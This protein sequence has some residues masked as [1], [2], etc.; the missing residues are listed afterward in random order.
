MARL[1]IAAALASASFVLLLVFQLLSS[2]GFP[3]FDFLHLRPEPPLGYPTSHQIPINPP[4]ANFGSLKDGT[5]YLLG[6]GK[7]DIT[8]YGFESH[9]K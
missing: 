1:P 2:F 8:G 3:K 4:S 7:A 5:R 6:V 9:G